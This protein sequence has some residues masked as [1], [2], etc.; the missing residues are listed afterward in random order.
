MSLNQQEMA[1][2]ERA[3]GLLFGN[4]DFARYCKRKTRLLV[5]RDNR[6]AKSLADRFRTD[7]GFSLSKNLASFGIHGKTSASKHGGDCSASTSHG[8]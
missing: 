4:A 7:S 5:Q 1:A 8:S 6:M 2:K 3:A